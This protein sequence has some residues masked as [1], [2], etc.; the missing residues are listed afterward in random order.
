MQRKQEG[1]WLSHDVCV[2]VFI[3]FYIIFM[4]CHLPLL[5]AKMILIW[6]IGNDYDPLVLWWADSLATRQ[7][8]HSQLVNLNQ[9]HLFLPSN[10]FGIERIFWQLS[11]NWCHKIYNTE[12]V[13][14]HVVLIV[15]ILSSLYCRFLVCIFPLHG[16]PW[17]CLKKCI[18]VYTIYSS[19]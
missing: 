14:P 4:G 12:K 10:H 19:L 17:S 3:D 2:F 11:F 15:L 13:Q 1:K 7:Y 5:W 16:S 18:V 9:L 8:P 6:G